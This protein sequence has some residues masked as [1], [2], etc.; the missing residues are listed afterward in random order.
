MDKK[1]YQ[2]LGN[3]LIIFN[4]CDVLRYQFKTVK[5]YKII[6]IQI[7]KEHTA[8]IKIRFVGKKNI[9]VKSVKIR[10]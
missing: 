5:I 8:E 4:K 2:N 3:F 10:K 6:K 1:K 9:Q 7:I